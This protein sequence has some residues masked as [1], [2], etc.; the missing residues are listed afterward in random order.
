MTKHKTQTL[1]PQSVV[2]YE[3]LKD[4]LQVALEAISVVAPLPWYVE[5]DSCDSYDVEI[6]DAEHNVL[7]TG[8][9]V[10]AA[11]AIDLVKRLNK[12][13]G[14][15]VPKPLIMNDELQS[16]IDNPPKANDRLRSLFASP[17]II[18]YKSEVL[19]MKKK[20]ESGLL[21]A[22]DEAEYAEALDEIWRD[23]SDEEI[24]II[25]EWIKTND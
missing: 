7:Y 16:I 6:Y 22:E 4:A 10:E 25:E 2:N 23:L 5:A 12:L 20:R 3:Y 13:G 24:K 19:E 15:I 17:S 14:L 1:H 8:I 18:M 11:W 9:D 21:S